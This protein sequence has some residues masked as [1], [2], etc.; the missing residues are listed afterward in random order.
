MI[1]ADR[2]VSG[3]PARGDAVVKC[4]DDFYAGDV[5]VEINFGGVMAA[6]VARR[7][8]SGCITWA[9]RRAD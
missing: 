6:E 8:Q 2:T 9:S 7:Q 5:A 1:L 3:S 4:H